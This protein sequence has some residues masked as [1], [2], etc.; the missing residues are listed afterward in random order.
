MKQISRL[1][2]VV[3]A[4]ANQSLIFCKAQ[5]TKPAEWTT[6]RMDV[7]MALKKIFFN[8]DKRLALYKKTG[9]Y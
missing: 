4:E 1:L 6:E 7:K 9:H 8:V 3:H 5:K 2:I